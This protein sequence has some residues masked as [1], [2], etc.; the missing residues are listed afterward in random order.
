MI[1]FR[2]DSKALLVPGVTIRG[3]SNNEMTAYSFNKKVVEE[4]EDKKRSLSR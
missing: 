2:N 4:I 1:R 3:A